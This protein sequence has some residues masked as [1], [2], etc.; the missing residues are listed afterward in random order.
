MRGVRKQIIFFDDLDRIFYL[1]SFATTT[2]KMGIQTL[3]LSIMFDHIHSINVFNDREEMAAFVRNHLSFFALGYNQDAGRKGSL[4]EKAY[5]NAPKWTLKKARSA[6]IYVGN[7][8]VEKGICKYA[9]ENRWSFIAYLESDHPFS[10]AID[11]K[12]ASAHF[13]RCLKSIDAF[14][15]QNTVIPYHILRKYFQPLSPLEKEQLTDYLISQ[16]NPIDKKA[17]LSYF[18][19]SFETFLLALHST[20]GSDYD[21]KEDFN[22]PT[23]QPFINLLNLCKR[24]SFKNNMKRIQTAPEK[25]KIAHLLKEISGE[26]VFDISRFLDYD[27]GG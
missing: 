11:R 18:G 23:H 7:N 3:S 22:V 24:S 13:R 9:E 1:M 26:S 27:G 19:D 6:I 21:I 10:P 25:E 15:K 20:T 14:R 4:L 12:K 8:H 17:V 2:R 16:Y 5:G